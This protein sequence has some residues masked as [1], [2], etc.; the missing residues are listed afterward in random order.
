M[1]D[2]SG[3]A[4][5]IVEA[6]ETIRIFGEGARQ[7]LECDGDSEGQVIGSVNFSHPPFAE[8]PDDL[9]ALR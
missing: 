9:I 2:L 5:L 8:K 1:R 4:H 7:E 6:A 3:N